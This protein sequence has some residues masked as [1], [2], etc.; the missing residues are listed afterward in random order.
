MQVT[1][2]HKLQTWTKGTGLHRWTP[3]VANNKTLE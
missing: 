2:I 1:D 3:R